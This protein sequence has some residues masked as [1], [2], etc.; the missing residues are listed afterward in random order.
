MNIGK[1]LKE[2]GV[3]FKTAGGD[4]G[5]ELELEAESPDSYGMALS[6]VTGEAPLQYWKI[7]E[8]S[9]LGKGHFNQEFIFRKPLT[10]ED[11]FA[12]IDEFH[13][14]FGQVPFIEDAPNASVHVHVD[15][16]RKT[17]CEMGNFITAYLACEN[18]LAKYAGPKRWSNFFALTCRDSSR[19]AHQLGNIM[20]KLSRGDKNA[21]DYQSDNVKYSALNIGRFKDL[22]TLEIRLM[23]STANP[24]TL[25]EWLKIIDQLCQF[26]KRDTN[27]N[28]IFARA[29]SDPVGLVK[30]IFQDMYPALTQTIH[31]CLSDD[32][33][34][35]Y[36]DETL[37]SLWQ[38]TRQLYSWENINTAFL[39][40]K[41]EIVEE[42]GEDILEPPPSDKS[43][44]PNKWKSSASLKISPQMAV[45]EE[46]LVAA[47]ETLYNLTNENV[48]E[49]DD[50]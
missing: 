33:V 48:G 5:M 18:L 47:T 38:F 44:L 46:Y 41:E 45:T 32:D 22:G 36:V 21:L 8:D 2:I 15:M 35:A 40:M 13:E 26:A 12:A 11:S 30:D 27:P 1:Q 14:V 10:L 20:G 49:S 17:L 29:K 6:Y 7:D 43:P 42:F 50:Y 28:E 3:K 19:Y 16:T 23:R 39:K 34:R 37:L 9:S 31:G 25:K 4:Y 24:N